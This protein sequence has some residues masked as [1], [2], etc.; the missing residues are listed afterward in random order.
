M[1]LLFPT[2]DDI[3]LQH[4]LQ[5]SLQ[6]CTSVQNYSNST[7]NDGQL[8]AS[9]VAEPSGQMTVD[10]PY[11]NVSARSDC[12]DDCDEDLMRAIERSL[13]E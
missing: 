4:A 1:Q 12:W 10:V 7:D 11:V 3:L 5:A 9:V 2:G 8:S 13:Q 6:D